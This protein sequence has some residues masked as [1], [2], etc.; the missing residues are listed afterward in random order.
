MD[1]SWPKGASVNNGVAKDIYLGTPYDL[2]YPS[3]DSITN[4]LRNLGPSGQSYKIDISR[5]FRH[6]KIDPGDIDVL[7]IKYQD[8]Y[9]LDRSVAFRYRHGSLIFQRCTDAIRYIMAQCGLPLSYNYIDDLIYTGLLSQI[10]DSF[11]FLN[12]LLGELGLDISSKKLVPPA[13]SVTCLGILVDSVS[14]MCRLAF[15][16]LL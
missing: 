10:N 13:T 14:V 7:G 11:T 15:E 4:S 5:A 9:F 8:H 6:I 16:N 12:K 1:L 3:V 2:N